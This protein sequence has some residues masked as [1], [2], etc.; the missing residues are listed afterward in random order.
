MPSDNERLRKRV[1]Q[2]IKPYSAAQSREIT[3]ANSDKLDY[4]AEHLKFDLA[5]RIEKQNQRNRW[6]RIFQWLVVINFVVSSV[7][8]VAIGLGWLK[9]GELSV[10][11]VVAAGVLETYGLSK[12]AVGYFFSEDKGRETR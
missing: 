11:V 1:L 9:F 3:S 8:I 2:A 12:L 10:P 7:L 5:V 6:N 4:G